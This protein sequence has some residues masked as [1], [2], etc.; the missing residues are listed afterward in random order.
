MYT[1][2]KSELAKLRAYYRALGRHYRRALVRGRLVDA[3]SIRE[4]RRRVHR[5]VLIREE[6]CV[7]SLPGDARQLGKSG[8]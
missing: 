8:D 7:D 1:A 5:S 6:W 3:M 2:R 4:R